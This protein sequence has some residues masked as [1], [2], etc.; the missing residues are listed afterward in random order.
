[1]LHSFSRTELLIGPEALRR[2]AGSKVA[3]FGIGGVGTFAVEGLAR[4]GVGK[5]VLVD[6]DCVCLTNINRQ[7]H[8]T[9][10][11]IGRPKVELMRERILEI[12][13]QA[14][15]K[16]FQKFYLPETAAEMIADDYDY[17]VD[18]VDTVTAKIDLVVRAKSRGIPIISA[19]GAGNKLDP[20]RFEVADLFA[21]SV[22]PL[23]KVM[24]K[25]LKA[26]GINA[27]KV[28]YSK[29][30][31][32]IPVETEDASC[33]T[34]CVCPQGTARTCTTRRHIPGSIAFVP[35]VAGLI[36][37]GEVV[38]DIAFGRL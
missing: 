3:V 33:A 38:K 17:I 18:A 28:V 4:S 24:R 36:I 12:N 16:V 31:P 7:L 34:G 21:T 30:K 11:T 23:A 9:T 27:L 25:E 1:M 8:A 37:A 15:V 29:E 20:T 2:L 22:D 6:D 35:S 14:E 13:P 5:F 26:R 19:M 32:L 10:K